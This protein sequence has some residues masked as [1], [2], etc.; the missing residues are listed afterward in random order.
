MQDH[1]STLQLHFLQEIKQLYV[2]VLVGVFGV[3]LFRVAKEFVAIAA[4]LAL[5]RMSCVRVAAIHAIQQ[6]IQC[7]AHEMILELVAFNHPNIL[8]MKV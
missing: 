3:A 1:H 4:P 6:L 7:G 8:S 2:R 5:H